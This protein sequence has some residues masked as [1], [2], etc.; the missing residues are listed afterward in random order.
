MEVERLKVE[1]LSI[2]E[3]IQKEMYEMKQEIQLFFPMRNLMY[4]LM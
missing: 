4:I 3:I 2:L 1:F